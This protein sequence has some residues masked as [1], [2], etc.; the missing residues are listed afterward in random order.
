MTETDLYGLAH[1]KTIGFTPFLYH[2]DQ[3]FFNVRSG[4]PIIDA[5]S[6]SSDLL[7]LAKSFAEDA[8]FIKDTDRHAWAA[9]Y[10]TVMGKALLDDVI[11]TLMP[12]S[13]RANAESEDMPDR[14]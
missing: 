6:Q 13:V 12:R 14:R 11:Q 5:L 4:I 3:A 2:S 1:L 7:Y 8:A 10:L 9:H